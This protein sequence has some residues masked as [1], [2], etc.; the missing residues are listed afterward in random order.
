MFWAP[1]AGPRGPALPLTALSGT[2]VLHKDAGLGR[3]AGPGAQPHCLYYRY[4]SAC[5]S[6]AGKGARA[7]SEGLLGPLGR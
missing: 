1:L 7:L 4:H 5:L 2:N 6:E 3:G